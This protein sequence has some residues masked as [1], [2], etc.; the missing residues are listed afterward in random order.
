MRWPS[1]RRLPNMGLLNYTTE[2]DPDKTAA[3]IAK[4]LTKHGA[5]AIM[6]EYDQATQVV[7]A[8]SFKITVGDQPLSFRLPC[9][10]KPVYKVMYGDMKHLPGKQGM[11]E[12]QAIRTAWRIVKSWVE[13]QMAL[14]EVRMATTQQVFLPY[15][16]MKD[17]R[18]LSEHV[19][20][21]PKF[22][23]GDGN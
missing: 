11:R 5:Q 18:T 17:G 4:C 21:N 10:W 15:A 2:I 14:V 23:L 12:L 3:E 6:T 20:S 8:L 19:S 16:V 7:T 1:K 22:L 13:A 9:D